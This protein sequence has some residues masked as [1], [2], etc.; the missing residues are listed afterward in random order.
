MTYSDEIKTR[1]STFLMGNYGLPPVVLR[2]GEDRQ[3]R[4]SGRTH[5]P[6]HDDA[7]N[8]WSMTTR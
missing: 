5:S 4:L 1:F 3:G 6:R 8:A 7:A 2:E